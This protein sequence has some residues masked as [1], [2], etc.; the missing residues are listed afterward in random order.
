MTAA[1]AAFPS[2]ELDLLEEP[3]PSSSSSSSRKTLN[4]NHL[5][6]D[7]DEG[8]DTNHNDDPAIQSI[9]SRYLQEDDDLDPEI[10]AALKFKKNIQV[11]ITVTISKF[12]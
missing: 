11:A 5:D 4:D 12:F 1:V 7:D 9:L 6:S 10:A 2:Y 8:F 3:Y